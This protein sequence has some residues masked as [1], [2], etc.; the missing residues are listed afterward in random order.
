[1]HPVDVYETR[2]HAALALGPAGPVSAP[3]V[4]VSRG[5]QVN[6]EITPTQKGCDGQGRGLQKAHTGPWLG[7]RGIWVYF[8]EGTQIKAQ[9]R[10]EYCKELGGSSWA[11]ALGAP[12]SPPRQETPQPETTC[13]PPRQRGFWILRYRWAHWCFVCQRGAG[14]WGSELHLNQSPSSAACWPCDLSKP[15]LLSETRFPHR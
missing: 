15:F 14:A 6:S 8:P 13:G 5:R 1:M 12:A 2:P 10:E 11:E 4:T 3:Q 7:L 9:R